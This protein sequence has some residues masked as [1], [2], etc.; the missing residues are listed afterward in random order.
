[1][2]TRD[3]FVLHPRLAADTVLVADWSLS[4]ILMMNDTR[5][6]WLIL[7]PRKKDMPELHELPP[8]DRNVLIEEIARA[9]ASLK[10]IMN[11]PKINIGALGNLVPQ[12][13]VHVVARFPSDPAWPGPVWG[14]G[15]PSPYAPADAELRIAELRARL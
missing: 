10:A 12:L 4:R 14:S 1:M 6:P 7:V 8:Q 11:A 5:F 13:H 15:P 9:G 3:D 2:A